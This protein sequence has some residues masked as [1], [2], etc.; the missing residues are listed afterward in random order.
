MGNK[1]LQREQYAKRRAKSVLSYP[2][3][4][5]SV[6]YIKKWAITALDVEGKPIKIFKQKKA[7]H[8]TF[9]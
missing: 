9:Y 3:V 6:P 4:K 8:V 1:L 7:N 2:T 5:S